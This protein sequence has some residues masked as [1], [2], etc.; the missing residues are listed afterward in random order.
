MR[1]NTYINNKKCKEWGLNANQGALF[2]LLNQASSWAEPHIIEN[3]VYYF[4]SR[5]KVIDEISLFYNKPDTVYRHFKILQEKGLI[6]YIKLGKKDLLKL[7]EKGK[8]WN[9][10]NSEMDSNSE[11][12]PKKLGNESEKSSEMN[13]TYNNTIL[14]NNTINNKEKN[15]VKKESRFKKPSIEEIKKYCEERKNKI[16]AEMFFN[17]Y[18][19]KGWLIGKNRMK[20]WKASVRVWE[21]K[22]KDYNNNKPSSFTNED[23]IPY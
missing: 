1:Y 20:N 8:T 13:P 15:I 10:I 14:D 12:N 17:F 2:D 18:E 16:N 23:G 19:A 4:V 3:E 7:T 22:Q 11:I 21:S 5:N 9:A 6:K